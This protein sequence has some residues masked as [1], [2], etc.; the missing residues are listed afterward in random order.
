MLTSFHCL[1][2]RGGNA[3][4]KETEPDMF[5]IAVDE[6]NDKPSRRRDGAPADKRMKTNHKRAG[7]NAKFGFGGK[8]RHAKSNDATSSADMT[9]YMKGRMKGAG[10]R[11]G[12]KSAAKARPGKARRAKGRL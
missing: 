4:D 9:G 6:E 10:G 7:K 12:T 2:E 5:D 3:I 11:P 8:K 1:T